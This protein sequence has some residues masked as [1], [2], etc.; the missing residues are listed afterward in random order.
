[1]KQKIYIGSHD[2]MSNADTFGR[3]DHAKFDGIHMYGHS[4]CKEFTASL[5]NIL[6]TFLT[7]QPSATRV[8]SDRDN[9]SNMKTNIKQNAPTS[10]NDDKTTNSVQEPSASKAPNVFR[11]AVKTFN[12]FSSFLY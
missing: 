12:R 11:Y 9:F 3:K 7:I 5:V 1:M 6:S 8:L 2:I 4:G 10:S